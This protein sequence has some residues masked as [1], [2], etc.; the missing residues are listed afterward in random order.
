MTQD[1]DPDLA[2]RGFAWGLAICLLAVFAAGF[3]LYPRLANNSTGSR[4]VDTVSF[5]SDN[6]PVGTSGRETAPDTGDNPGSAAVV[7]PAPI[8]D[9]DTITGINDG[10]ELVGQRVDLHVPV[11]EHI[12]D[13]A[14]WVGSDDNRLLVVLARDDRDDVQR[15]KGLP[16]SS[17]VQALN[18]APAAISGTV[19]ALPR[20]E[21]MQSWGLTNADWAELMQRKIYIRADNVG[22]LHQ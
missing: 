16:S 4:L 8:Q 14:F 7:P 21:L 6:G 17:K 5:G 19:Q 22:E 13:V 3:L 20:A 11:Q 9:L 12:N 10:R 2:P 18:G 1:Q 15:Q